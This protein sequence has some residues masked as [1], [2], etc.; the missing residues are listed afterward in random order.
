MTTQQTAVQTPVNT[1]QQSQTFFADRALLPEG[2]RNNVCIEVS[3]GMISTVSS[4]QDCPVG[5]TRLNGPAL[6]TIANLHSHAFQ[7]IMAGLCEVSLDPNDNFWSWRDTMYKLV[8][9]LS[10][11]DVQ[12]I[13][14]ELY[15]D[16]L[17]AGY[18]QVAEFNYL[19]HNPDGSYYD[20]PAEMNLQLLNAAQ[21]TG[22][23][24]T[25]APVLYS[26]GGFGAQPCNQAQQRFHHQTDDYLKL[27]EQIQ[28]ATSRHSHT[29][30]QKLAVCFHSIRAV[31]AGQMREVLAAQD[32]SV[33]VHIHIAEQQK[34][35][36]DC[37][38]HYG[39]RP[40]E[41]L[42]NELP[43]DQRWCLIHATHLND[44][45]IRQMAESRA[46]A[47]LCPTTEANLGDGIFPATDFTLQQG[48][49][50]VGSDSHVSLSVAEELRLLE[51]SQRLR[52]QQRNR[53]YSEQQTS[54]GDF[55]FH[56]ALQGGAQACGIKQGIQTGCRADFMTLDE[57]HAEI[58]G[59]QSEQL[60]NRWIFACR[61]N[62]VKDVYVA[63]QATIT[64]GHHPLE[65]QS[66]ERYLALQ[67]R[68]QL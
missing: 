37:L 46:V 39:Q 20:N 68:L 9:L 36:Q 33:P 6:P 27:L 23:G 63:G 4:N 44:Q 38:A 28:S 22:L 41:W 47:G 16:M 45:E 2:W 43:V 8:K 29:G 42:Y 7:R 5:A 25:L 53:L 26:Y 60:L 30:L 19:H 56:G 18:S 13:A 24:I 14:T 49:F 51:Y 1:T 64:D 55:L 52:D 50:G 17:K 32:N 59:C 10:P 54:I 67:R 31:E 11:E 21:Q 15:I 66:R 62:P 3:G 48:V 57:N 40:V 61:N 65:A 58:G 34:E 12:I 35:V